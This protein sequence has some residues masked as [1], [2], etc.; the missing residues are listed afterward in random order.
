MASI[1]GKMDG[2][3]KVISRTTTAKD[4]V[5][6]MMARVTLT[7]VVFGIMGSRARGRLYLVKA[8]EISTLEVYNLRDTIHRIEQLGIIMID[9][10]LFR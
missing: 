7:I 4:M 6:Y 10:M 5:S 3:T 2:A 9:R 1:R 8:K